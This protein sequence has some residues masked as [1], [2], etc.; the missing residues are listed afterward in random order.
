MEGRPKSIRGTGR[1]FWSRTSCGASKGRCR[2][3]TDGGGGRRVVDTDKGRR[4]ENLGEGGDS[5][6]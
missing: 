2:R 4:R 1:S 3:G 6:N 5:R